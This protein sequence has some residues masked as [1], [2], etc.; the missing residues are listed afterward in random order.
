MVLKI[1]TTKGQSKTFATCIPHLTVFTVFIVT[2]CFVYLKPPSNVPS[3]TD[4]F[5]SVLY[6]VL[7]PAFN[8]LVYTL[9]NSDVKY[10]M[11]RLLQNHFP[12]GSCHLTPLPVSDIQPHKLQAKFVILDI[13]K[14]RG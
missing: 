2:A 3:I 11:R 8:P 10:A 6:T 5:L 13:G 4:R 1:P 9:R 12:S 7:P 14:T